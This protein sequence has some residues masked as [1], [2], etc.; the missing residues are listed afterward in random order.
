MADKLPKTCGTC[1][2]FC[3]KPLDPKN[4]SERRGECRHSPPGVTV[5]PNGMTAAAYPVLP[6]N[7]AACAQ[8]APRPIVSGEDNSR[9]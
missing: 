9:G 1:R 7:Y 3:L 8:H 2:F 5:L 6:P 4:L